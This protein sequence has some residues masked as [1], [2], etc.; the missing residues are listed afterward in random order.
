MRDAELKIEAER[1]CH[2]STTRYQIENTNTCRIDVLKD[3]RE[4]ERER[5]RE[6]TVDEIKKKEEDETK[7][8]KQVKKERGEIKIINCM[9]VKTA[10]KKK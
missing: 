8:E 6:F 10:E 7:Q 2:C 3:T 5:E 4:R 1:W 9:D